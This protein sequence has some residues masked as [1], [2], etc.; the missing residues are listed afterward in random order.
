MEETSPPP[1]KI[2]SRLKDLL[3]SAE[4]AYR[5]P[6]SHPEEMVREPTRLTD[7]QFVHEESTP[8]GAFPCFR[9]TFPMTLPL[10]LPSDIAILWHLN[11]V[12]IN[13]VTALDIETAAPLGGSREMTFTVGLARST[14]DCCTLEQLVLRGPDDEMAALWY[15]EEAVRATDLIVT[16][17]GSRFDLPILGRRY[18]SLGFGGFDPPCPT[19]DL[20]PFARNVFGG[21]GFSTKLCS[22]EERILSTIRPSWIWHQAWRADEHLSWKRRRLIARILAKNAQDVLSLLTLLEAICAAVVKPGGHAVELSLYMGRSLLGVANELD[23]EWLLRAAS[24]GRGT[25]TGLEAALLAWK[26]ADDETRARVLVPTL[27]QA[28]MHGA[29]NSWRAA[30][31]LGLAAWRN[32]DYEEAAAWTRRAI[33][34]AAPERVRPTLEQRLARYRAKCQKA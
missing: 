12:H 11:T 8:Y 9:E 10:C 26:W 25:P 28:A 33:S 2:I 21:K 3:R 31:R 14:A 6:S 5:M 24:T 27:K 22:L 32:H 15:L 19:V 1:E 29:L 16:Y 17:N 30:E 23:M 13:H 20:E 4:N 34:L 18:R 7:A